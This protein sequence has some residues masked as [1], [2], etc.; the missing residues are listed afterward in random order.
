MLKSLGWSEGQAL[1]KNE[2][3]LLEPVCEYKTDF[4]IKYLFFIV[5]YK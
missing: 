3:G 2:D 5:H 4:F 1:G